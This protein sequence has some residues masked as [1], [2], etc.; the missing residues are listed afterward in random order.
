MDN[1]KS[2]VFIEKL[3]NFTVAGYRFSEEQSQTNQWVFLRDAMI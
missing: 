2:S 3:K 1:I